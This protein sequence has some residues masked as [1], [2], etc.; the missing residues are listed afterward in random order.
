[1]KWEDRRK[2]DN[3]DNAGSGSGG[4]KGIDIGGG[5]LV[6][7]LLIYLFTGDPMAAFEGAVRSGDDQYVQEEYT[8]S[9]EEEQLYDYSAVVLADTEDAWS[10][11]LKE[12]NMDYEPAKM[13]IFKDA[14]KTGCGLANSGVG[15]FYCSVDKAVYMDLSFYDEL[16]NKFGADDGDFVL[17][18]V[19]SHEIG[20]HVQNVTGVMDDYQKQMASLS[21][22]DQNALTVRLEL[23][24]DYLAGVV[25]KYQDDKG[26]LDPGDIDEAV[27]AAWVIG[28]DTLQKEAYGEVRPES[29]THGTSEQRTRWFKKGYEKGDL[30]DWDTFSLDKSDL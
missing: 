27:S 16:I 1:M 10:E 18:Y 11:I 28:D 25:A 20:H 6:I 23:Q 3:I 21:K 30:S 24:A 22:K 5:R 29:Y 26:Y 9:P 14:I 19:I 15:P 7:A 4:G 12:E 17:S 13:H 2:S 8:L